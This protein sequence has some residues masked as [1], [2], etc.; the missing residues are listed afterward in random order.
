MSPARPAGRLAETAGEQRGRL[1][2]RAHLR[3]PRVGPQRPQ[4]LPG[5]LRRQLRAAGDE[6]RLPGLPGQCHPGQGRQHR[7]LV[8]QQKKHPMVPA[9]RISAATRA[10][11]SRLRTSRQ[12][13]GGRVSNP[14]SL[15]SLLNSNSTNSRR[16]PSRSGGPGCKASR[17]TS[18]GTGA[19]QHRQAAAQA[20]L[21]GIFAA[22]LPR[23]AF[24]LISSRWASRFSRL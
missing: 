19:L 16:R 1:Q 14:S 9:A 4:N 12:V 24:S 10:K 13:S 20:R 17:S 21:L 5:R 22:I 8:P 15:T 2:V 23:K 6:G 18:R 7:M 11:S 3:H